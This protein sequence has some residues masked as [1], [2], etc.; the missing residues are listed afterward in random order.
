[1]HPTE[2]YAYRNRRVAKYIRDQLLWRT[3]QAQTLVRAAARRGYLP[4]SVW[5]RF[6]PYGL[7][8]LPTPDG[9]TFRY[10]S[11]FR[12]DGLARHIVWTDM[13]DWEA[14]TQPVIFDL[15]KTAGTFVDVGAYSGIYTLLACLA[16]PELHA[17]AFEPNPMKL[18]QLRANVAA[19]GLEDRV[20]IIEKALAA[21]SGTAQ[22]SIPSDDSTASLAQGRPGDRR[23]DVA[24]TT[25]D[26]ALA[27]L[28]VNLIKIDVEGSEA[29]VL[30]G[31]REVL[32]THHPAIIAECLDEQALQRLVGVTTDNGYRHSY[33]LCQKGAVPVGDIAFHP[34]N[35]LFTVNSTA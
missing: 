1:M 22:L 32:R 9:G 26:Q 5:T 12:H 34:A 17:I 3:P 2:V 13:Q 27:G 4:P 25:G 14:A 21:A 11:T 6:H 19:N 20:T 23:V 35:Y 33:Q 15:A 30:L 31:M 10:D 28:P 7:W 18:P 29:E 8:D 16:N 24:L